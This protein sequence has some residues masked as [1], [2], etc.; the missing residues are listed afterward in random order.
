M[1]IRSTRTHE[2]TE[3]RQ[4][5]TQ[6]AGLAAAVLLSGAV[7]HAEEVQHPWVVAAPL[8]VKET[9]FSN[10]GSGAR[11][12]TPFVLKFGLSG[13]GL[14]PIT[15][16]QPRT[17]HHHLL[18]NRELPLDFS[19]PLPFNEQYVHFG[20][21][22]M[23][24]VL[25]LAPG[26]YTLRLVLADDKH[27]PNF[28]YSKPLR[29][30]VTKKNADLDPASLGP[31]GV[32]LMLPVAE[33]SAGKPLQVRFHASRLNVSHV[34]LQEKGTGHF[35]LS[36]LRDGARPE[37]LDFPGGQTEAWIKAPPGRYQLRLEFVDNLAPA[38]VLATA[39]AQSITVLPK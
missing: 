35:R 12:E 13:M 22:Q 26:D 30:T 10:L 5:V 17:G 37:T 2:E 28:V 11:I 18:I 16:P 14:A 20:K 27:I 31:P 15:K 4:C 3:M 9:Y 24:T 1:L 29:V 39:A 34:A 23:E 33:A 21:G 36:A 25:T 32:E 8:S 7:S 38:T 19:K 6:A